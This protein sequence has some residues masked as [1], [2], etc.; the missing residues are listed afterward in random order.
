MTRYHSS[1]DNQ[2]KEYVDR[3]DRPYPYS[4]IVQ[5]FRFMDLPTELRIKIIRYAL[6]DKY[7][8][9]FRW[10]TY[11]SAAKKGCLYSYRINAITQT[12]RQVHVESR[13]LFW[14]TNTI[15]FSGDICKSF[16]DAKTEYKC[17]HVPEETFAK[18]A[19]A[20]FV[21][22][23]QPGK[24]APVPVSLC[25]ELYI[26]AE[27]TF[28]TTLVELHDLI[29][30][31]TKDAPNLSISIADRDWSILTTYLGIE[32]ELASFQEYGRNLT[33]ALAQLCASGVQRN[34]KVFPHVN[35][36]KVGIVKRGLIAGGVEEAEE[37]IGKG[38]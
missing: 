6:T 32:K 30:T 19:I 31:L 28:Q 3:F 2:L 9:F 12:C 18:D 17:R 24:I 14:Q 29:A 15:Q 23:M 1:K 33:A 38:V 8:P 13:N 37:W 4:P 5:P 35:P 26:G 25:L 21:R 20:F 36:F 27:Y 22:S 11:T 16:E 34:W 7:R 10:T